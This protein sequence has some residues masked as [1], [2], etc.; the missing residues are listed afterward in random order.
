[1]VVAYDPAWP[2]CFRHERAQLER[3]L[4]AWLT[5]SIEHIGSTAIPG[6]IAKP[7]IDLMA[8]VA[9]LESSRTAIPAVERAGYVHF[10]YRVEVMHWFCKPSAAF[11]T[12]HLHLVPLGSRLWRERLAFR[13]RLRADAGLAAEYGALKTHLAQRHPDD[14]EAYTD[15]KGPFIDRVLAAVLPIADDEPRAGSPTPVDSL[16][17]DRR[18][19]R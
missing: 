6:M 9:D 15:G 1:M 10:P 17:L 2:A 19:P 4:A 12:H 11:R 8:P 7:V 5:G 3:V 16:T 18:L 14:R 13:D